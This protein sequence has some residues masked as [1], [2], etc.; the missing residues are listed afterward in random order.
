M[1][2]HGRILNIS[3]PMERNQ[4]RLKTPKKTTMRSLTSHLRESSLKRGNPLRQRRVL[5]ERI[6][7]YLIFCG[8][9]VPVQLFIVV[10]E[11]EKGYV[12][13]GMHVGL[14]A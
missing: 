10:P 3:I 4:R 12:N 1:K 13:C 2:V 5:F 14:Y 7:V 11:P 8:Q 9:T 6:R